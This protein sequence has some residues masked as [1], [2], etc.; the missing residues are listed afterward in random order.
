MFTSIWFNKELNLRLRRMFFVALVYNSLIS[1]LEA[2]VLSDSEH[3]RLTTFL[4]SRSRALLMGKA[5]THN[6]DEDKHYA[7]TNA[8]VLKRCRL[9][10]T[11]LELQFRRLEW[12]QAL[13]RKPEQGGAMLAAWFGDADWDKNETSN[14]WVQ[15]FVQDIQVLHQ[16]EFQHIDEIV[17]QPTILFTKI[18]M[19]QAFLELDITELRA[20]WKHNLNKAYTSLRPGEDHP[21]GVSPCD[22]TFEGRHSMP[23]RCQY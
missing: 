23:I 10:F 8:V 12:L 14:I 22:I 4:V 18:S 20:I 6:V 17:E 21:T 11:H 15:Q 9:L 2:F 19:R 1:A 5:H 16:C 7:W 13:A 3:D